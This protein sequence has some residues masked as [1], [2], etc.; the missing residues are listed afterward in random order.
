MRKKL[1]EVDKRILKINNGVNEML[2]DIHKEDTIPFLKRPRP[3]RRSQMFDPAQ[4]DKM[5]FYFQ[6]K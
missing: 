4:K 2:R 1:E 5:S 3:N 6:S